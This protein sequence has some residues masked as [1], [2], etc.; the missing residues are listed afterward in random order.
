[1]DTQW[2]NRK[3]NRQEFQSRKEYGCSIRKRCIANVR[4]RQCD[5][6]KEV[7]QTLRSN[8]MQRKQLTHD[9]RCASIAASQ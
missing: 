4:T 7:E 1:M 3:S 5:E 8:S 6:D 2:R 9:F